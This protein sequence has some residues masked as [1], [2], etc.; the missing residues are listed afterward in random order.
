MLKYFERMP[1]LFYPSN[2]KTSSVNKKRTK[3]NTGIRYYIIMIMKI[4]IINVI[5]IFLGLVY[6]TI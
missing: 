6:N 4:A 5:N 1:A 2:N 3:C